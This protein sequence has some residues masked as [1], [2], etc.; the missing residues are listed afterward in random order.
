MEATTL[1]RRPRNEWHSPYT[2]PH[3]EVVS[4]QIEIRIR[5]D[6]SLLRSPSS[7]PMRTSMEGLSGVGSRPAI[8]R[9]PL[10]RP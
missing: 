9:R 6:R 7:V 5:N 3:P 4:G 8:F 2:E 10:A 1:S